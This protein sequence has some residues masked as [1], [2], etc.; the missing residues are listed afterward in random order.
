M[1]IWYCALHARMPSYHVW[2]RSAFPALPQCP[3]QEPPRAQQLSLPDCL[4]VPH[5][6]H[7][8]LMGVVVTVASDM[9]RMIK[10]A[11][12]KHNESQYLVG[13]LVYAVV[14]VGLTFA[15]VQ[16]VKPAVNHICVAGTP[17]VLVP[18]TI[19]SATTDSTRFLERAAL[20]TYHN[21]RG[22]SMRRGV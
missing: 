16:A 14:N 13:A 22:N 6:E 17:T 7:T 8:G 15:G 5:M 11:K 1:A 2:S 19:R 4:I 10:R 18:S 3:N 12:T 21:R 20:W 9:R